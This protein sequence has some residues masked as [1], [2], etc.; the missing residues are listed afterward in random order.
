MKQLENLYNKCL[1]NNL[2][3]FDVRNLRDMR[4]FYIIFPKWNAVRSELTWTHYRLRLK[5]ITERLP[6]W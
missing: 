1:E 2:E 6:V 3:G 5:G 4:S